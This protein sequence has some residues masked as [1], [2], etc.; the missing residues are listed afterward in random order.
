MNPDQ[1]KK[2]IESLI[3]ESYNGADDASSVDDFIRQLEAREKDL[4]ITA[5]TSIIEIAESFDDANLPEFLVQDLNIPAAVTTNTASKESS[6]ERVSQLESEIERLRGTIS[7]MELERA[8]IFKN[9][10]RRAKDFENFKARSERERRETFQN[11]LANLA[12]YLLP[13]LDNF[14]RAIDSAKDIDEAKSVE[15]QHFFDGVVLVN[16]QIYDIL[17]KMGIETIPTVGELFD[18]HLH[19][20]VATDP[21]EDL[22]DNTI[23]EELLRGFRI[24]DR[25]VRHSMVKV[26]KYGKNPQASANVSS[27]EPEFIES[28][29]PVSND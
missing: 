26:V 23:S 3:D 16:E 11:Q 20:A 21:R 19:E 25:V 6:N 28:E 15:F 10:Q 18:P 29:P 2:E 9:S 24:G 7:N 1:D 4:H 27:D 12:T 5:E 8:E 13:A 17:G 14:N 22:P